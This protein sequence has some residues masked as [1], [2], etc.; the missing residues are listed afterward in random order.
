MTDQT[1]EQEIQAKG[2][3]APRITPADIEAN[4]VHTEIVK[5]VSAGG[6]IMRWAVITTRNGYAVTGRPSVAVSPANDNAELGEKMAV[7]N[8]RNELWPLMGYALKDRLA[9]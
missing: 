9:G 1:I 4:I 5:H 2:L 3:T 7:D 6:Q 8:A